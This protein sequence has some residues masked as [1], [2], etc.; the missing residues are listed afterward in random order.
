M[1]QLAPFLAQAHEQGLEVAKNSR[2]RL[3]F[4]SGDWIPVKLPD[5]VRDVFTK[6]EVVSLGGATEATVWS[7]YYRIAEVDPL[8]PSI[9]YGKPIQNAEYYI[10]DADLH[11]CPTGVPGDLYIGG[12][13]LSSGYVNDPLLTAE[14]FIPHPFTRQPDARLYKTGDLARWMADGNMEFLGR[15]DHQVKI[16]GFRIELG[17]IESKLLSHEWITEAVVMARTDSSNTRYLCAYLVS[18]QELTVAELR[19]FLAKELPE[20]MIPSYF[21]GLGAMPVTVNGKLDRKALPEPDGSMD[22]GVQYLPPRNELDEQLLQIWQEVLGKK[23]I[24]IG[25]NFFSLGGHSLKATLLTA[26]IHQELQIDVPIREVFKS[27]TVMELANYIA[28]TKEEGLDRSSYV[29]IEPVAEQDYYQV[30][31]A[32][33]RLYILD[34]LEGASINYNIPGVMYLE[35]EV[36]QASFERT[37]TELVHRHE[38]FRTSF[39]TVDGKIVQRVHANVELQIIYKEADERE[40]PDVINDFIQPFDLSVAPLLRVALIQLPKRSLLVYDMHHII[41]D[42]VSLNILISD[43][44]DLYHGRELADLRIQYKDFAAWQNEFLQSEKI[45]RHE[46]YWL[47]EFAPLGKKQIPVLDLPTDAPRPALKSTEGGAVN[48]RLDQELVDSIMEFT[49]STGT[50]PYMFLLAAYNILLAKYS[51]QDDLVIGSP[52]AGRSHADLEKIVG[53]F[54]NMLPMRNQPMGEKQFSHFLHEVKEKVLEC[55]LNQ[56]YQFEMLVDKLNLERDLSRNPLFD[57]VFVMQNMFDQHTEQRTTEFTLQEYQYDSSIAKFDLTLSIVQNEGSFQCTFNYATKLFEQATIERMVSHFTNILR[58]VVR[59]P[60]MRIVALDMLSLAEKEQLLYQFNDTTATYPAEKTIHQIFAE[61]AQLWPLRRAV[62]LNEQSLSYQ[63]LNERANQV[64]HWLR[65]KGV[66]PDSLV[67]IMVERSLELIVGIMGIL[68]AGGAYVPIDPESPTQRIAYMLADAQIAQLLTETAFNS[69]LAG[70]FAGEII[71][72][73]QNAELAQQP[74]DNLP[75]ITASWHLAYIIYT[76]G[77]TGLPK[78]MMIEHRNVVRLLKSQPANFDF[79]EQDV[80]T[81]FHS[82]CFDFSVWE[83]FGALLFGGKLVIVDRESRINPERFLALLKKERV[84]VLNQTPQAFYNLVDAELK[85]SE[86]TL[87]EHL[88][89]VIFGGEALNF[90]KLIPWVRQYSLEEIALI[91]MYGITETTVH[92]TYERITESDLYQGYRSLIGRPIYTNTLYLLDQNQR[93]VPVGV[94]GEICVGGLGLGRGYLNRPEL[95]AEKFI[96]NPFI[97]NE[98][99]YRSGDLGKFLPD[100]NIEYLGRI[101]HQVKIRGFRI[102]IGEIEETLLKYND[103][104]DAVVID[105]VDQ[106]GS[107]YL[108]GYLVVN[109]SFELSELKN[110]LLKILPDYMV[111]TKFVILDQLPITSN[112]KI[113]R[114]ALP[115]PELGA[116]SGVEYVPPRDEVE[117]RVAQIWAK[118]LEV[119]RV[120]VHD[121][122]FEVGGNS[123]NLIKV[124]NELQEQFSTAQLEMTDLFKHNT[125]AALAEILRTETDAVDDEIEEFIM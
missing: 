80:W 69:L 87:N 65:A 84:T 45:K 37:F 86:H 23:K 102:E 111:P 10:L 97:A 17:E 11:P 108:V 38:S 25:D 101:D 85:A 99:L 18:E 2:L 109:D 91:N 30:S 66:G 50:T 82:Y 51:G 89:Y 36:E 63:E 88:R 7:N 31:S 105:R 8:W 112:G 19:D 61:Q 77:S 43:F 12:E 47:H 41:S 62:V 72:L 58:A 32:Q 21:V 117:E 106:H 42:G 76:S 104:R 40:G 3:V 122:F 83:I 28:V 64:A 90:S 46:E 94:P 124:F 81:L 93:L 26:K 114:K 96:A 119:E 15:A 100:G 48:F 68:K 5:L 67:G 113:D 98:R 95:T 55:F 53:M 118:V 59:Q 24:G 75:N 54:V 123:L 49:H 22:T 34:Q 78:G 35:G 103:V 16:R 44:H 71:N 120:G 9:P 116:F 92:V 20:Y 27:P 107:R 6:A 56:D 13:C 115:E 79:T 110:H 39:H 33:K 74:K 52:V 1:Q 57:V 121:N 60:E 4:L 125:I 14:K 70:E 29:A 73:D